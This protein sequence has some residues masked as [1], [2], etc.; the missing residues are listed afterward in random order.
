MI[1]Y[2]TTGLQSLNFHYK[3]RR[4]SSY[5]NKL[6]TNIFIPGITENFTNIIGVDSNGDLS[7]QGTK[8]KISKGL[9]FFIKPNNRSTSNVQISTNFNNLLG[10]SG[11]S[12]ISGV[13]LQNILENQILKCD[14]IKDFFVE[15][16]TLPSGVVD[17]NKSYILAEYNYLEF[18]E[19][20]VEFYCGYTPAPHSNIIVLGQINFS[21]G[22]I[23]N[24]NI[25][26][27]SLSQLNPNILYLMDVDMVN[28]YHA[29]NGSGYIPVSNGIMNIGL[30]ADLLNGYSGIDLAKKWQQNSSLNAQYLADEFGVFHNPG[31]LFDNIPLS[32][33]NTNLG[34]N[35]ELL[36]NS[37]INNYE[38]VEHSHGLDNIL[39]GPRFKR[40]LGVSINHLVTHDSFKNGVI[41]TDKINPQGIFSEN[42]DLTGNKIKIVTG[43]V[44]TS[45]N[46]TLVAFNEMFSKN[47][48]VLLQILD[49]GT[50]NYTKQHIKYQATD[51][52]PTHFT[53]TYTIY[54]ATNPGDK[55]IE[56]L[57]SEITFDFMAIGYGSKEENIAVGW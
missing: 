43:Q 13:W 49:S 21:G 11:I 18:K 27:Q 51:I 53:F 26:N 36:G 46:R 57:P 56:Q 17:T 6:F 3:L 2:G 42:D 29:G 10:Y 28:G 12:G 15:L 37:G 8:I 19:Q 4:I 55:F 54:E 50:G 16:A 7:T 47:P 52:T 31:N 41:T 5:F 34:L 20:E 1:N 32:N 14:V 9:S 40:L 39:D 33:L 45:T 22:Y 30:N 44:T 23:Q 38:N 24:I 48:K 35:A 25:S